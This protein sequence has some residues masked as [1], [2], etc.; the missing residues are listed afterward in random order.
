MRSSRSAPTLDVS[1]L[2]R[3]AKLAAVASY[4]GL[5]G[6]DDSDD[7]S[8]SVSSDG[9]EI[10]AVLEDAMDALD[11]SDDSS[12]ESDCDDEELL[13]T[14]ALPFGGRN[15][16]S[17]HSGKRKRTAKKER[18]PS[19]ASGERRFPKSALVHAST[20][21]NEDTVLIPPQAPMHSGSLTVVVDLDETVVWAR[22]AQIVVRPF[23]VEMLL[24]CVR[25][26]CEVVVW[27]ASVPHYV[28]RILHSVNGV[29]KRQWYHYVVAR[30]P[31][32]FHEGSASVKDLNYLRRDLSRVLVIENSPASVQLQQENV[33]L[34]EDFYG[35]NH[36]D[37][38]LI[39]A[40]QVIERVSHGVQRG[41][42][43]AESLHEDPVVVPVVFELEPEH[44]ADGRG[45]S[46]TSCGLRYSPRG[47]GCRVYAG[48]APLDVGE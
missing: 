22:N 34:V 2:L 44:S 15:P 14:V 25:N 33:L 10:V 4:D 1:S 35:D 38:S 28:N 45:A 23:V 5:V 39:F 16:K 12:H 26:Q 24:A 40:G 6:L 27:T 8:D 42:T 13:L 29:A 43:V 47:R 37:Q 21:A 9:T 32:W 3:A 18:H 20:H 41:Q 36:D 19:N 11:S 46:V 31:L 48:V 30:S 7:N 17:P